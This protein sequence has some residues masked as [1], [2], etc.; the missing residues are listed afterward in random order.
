[1]RISEG[2]S[3]A[4]TMSMVRRV[5]AASRRWPDSRICSS[6]SKVRP[7]AAA[8]APVTLISLPRTTTD[9]AGVGVLDEAEQLV[10]LSEQAHHEVVARHGAMGLG[11]S[12]AAIGLGEQV[13]VSPVDRPPLISSRWRPAACSAGW[14]PG[15]AGGRRRRRWRPARGGVPAPHGGRGGPPSPGWCSIS[16]SGARRCWSPGRRPS[17]PGHGRRRGCRLLRAA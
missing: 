11:W 3:S 4:F 2:F 12:V 8:S 14:A 9:D 13:T 17:P 6:S 5:A 16:P 10:A 15:A 1:M 7:A